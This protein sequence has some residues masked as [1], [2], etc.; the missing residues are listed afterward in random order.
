MLL[1]HMTKTAQ[2]L[3]LFAVVGTAIV[4]FTH[5][6]TR[7]QVDENRHQAVLR[8]LNALVPATQH[9]NDMLRDTIKVLSPELLGSRQ[10]VLVYLARK[11]GVPVA[12]VFEAIAPDGYSGTIKLL[13]AIHDDG[14]IA[15]VRVVAHRETP[16]LGDYIE[17]DRSDWILGFDGRSLFNP[18]QP[19]WRVKKDGGEFDQVTGATVTPR[20]I[21]KA[22]RNCLDYFAKHRDTLFGNPSAST[23]E[24][25]AP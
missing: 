4:A 17:L 14:T 23:M 25:P 20:A 9:D 7:Q 11:E 10:P 22:V 3:A 2:A 21:V 18:T 8:S 5:L 1:R 16:G 15:G 13:I 24:R 6:N 19:G 12:A